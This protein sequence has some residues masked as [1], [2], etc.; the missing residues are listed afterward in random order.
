MHLQ[1]FNIHRLLTLRQMQ[2]RCR[3]PLQLLIFI[4]KER[5]QSLPRKALNSLWMRHPSPQRLSRIP[6]RFKPHASLQAK[7]LQRRI[8]C[9]LLSQ[10][11][12]RAVP[13]LTRSTTAPHASHQTPRSLDYL[14]KTLRSATSAIWHLLSPLRTKAQTVLKKLPRG[15]ASWKDPPVTSPCCHRNRAA[16]RLRSLKRSRSLPSIYS[17]AAMVFQPRTIRLHQSRKHW[18]AKLW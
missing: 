3:Q 15:W 10:M 2:G 18:V 1:L 5:S 6:L 17:S 16:S 9:S 13:K 12:L 14:A 7:L 8:L 11:P 4:R